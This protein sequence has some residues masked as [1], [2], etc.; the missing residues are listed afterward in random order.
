MK[1]LDFDKIK[2]GLILPTGIGLCI[3]IFGFLLNLILGFFGY[4]SFINT[5][6]DYLAGIVGLVIS[7]VSHLL[8]L[9]LFFWTGYRT[10]YKYHATV[11]EGGVTAALSYVVIAFIN[12]GLTLLLT[13]LSLAN[14]GFTAGVGI[15]GE[16]SDIT[17]ALFGDSFE[18]GIG[19]LVNI[20]CSMGLI[21]IGALINFVVGSL[22]GMFGEKK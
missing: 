8:F 11:I 9:L 18:G 5:I 22:G 16:H 7:A 21:P 3:I 19:I 10:V 20:C 2:A 1:K 6:I 4:V 12:L 14:I 17:I 13:V 15:G